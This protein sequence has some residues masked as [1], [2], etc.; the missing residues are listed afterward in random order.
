MGNLDKYDVINLTLGTHAGSITGRD[1]IQKLIYFTTTQIPAIPVKY[2]SHYFG[3]SSGDV[4]AGLAELVA[5]SFV[6]ERDALRS[7]FSSSSYERFRYELTPD[8]WKIFERT[9][10]DYKAQ[11][12][13]ISNIVSTCD[14]YCK[15]KTSSLCFAAKLHYTLVQQTHKKETTLTLNKVQDLA[16]DFGWEINDRTITQGISILE[17]LDLASIT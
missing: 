1:A 13:T 16:A 12:V 14:A 5:F 15:L 17:S 7:S 6:E 8:G 9:K 3:P 10:D 4:A 11:Y 2:V